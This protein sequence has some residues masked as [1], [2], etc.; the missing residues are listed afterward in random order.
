MYGAE[1]NDG[2]MKEERR[3]GLGLDH[4]KLTTDFLE[5]MRWMKIKRQDHVEGGP[6]QNQR[7]VSV[8]II[9][10]RLRAGT[11]SLSDAVEGGRGRCLLRV[12][13]EREKVIPDEKKSS[14]HKGHSRSRSRSREEEFKR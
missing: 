14:R 3:E 5:E 7:R 10:R 11:E 1:E 6:G 9:A 13:I 4:W 8:V 2:N 12:G